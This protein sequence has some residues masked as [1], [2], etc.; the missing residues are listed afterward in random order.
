[1]NPGI[2]V[3][4][5]RIDEG[6]TGEHQAAVNATAQEGGTSG[7]LSAIVDSQNFLTC[8]SGHGSDG[9]SLP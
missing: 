3:G 6:D 4:G 5:I 2:D 8:R 9:Q 7:E 1:M